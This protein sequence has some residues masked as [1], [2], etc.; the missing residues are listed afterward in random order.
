MIHINKILG[1]KYIQNQN[2]RHTH[3]HTNSTM[4]WNNIAFIVHQINPS[5]K[6]V[7][8]VKHKTEWQRTAWKTNHQC[9]WKN[10]TKQY[11]INTSDPCILINTSDLV[12]LTNASD[13]VLNWLSY[14][15]QLNYTWSP[16]PPPPFHPNPHSPS[17]DPKPWYGENYYQYHTLHAVKLHEDSAAEF[18][19]HF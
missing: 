15:I 6:N 14:Q 8:H 16:P 18:N 17:S 19:D 1:K 13:L 10:P 5:S 9:N 11:T 4:T 2:R 3:T 12:K 7:T